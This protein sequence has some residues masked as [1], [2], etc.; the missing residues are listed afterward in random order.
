LKTSAT[1]LP[2]DSSSSESPSSRAIAFFDLD[3]TMTRT[4]VVSFYARYRMN[5]VPKFMRPFWL[6]LF[7]VKVL[8]YVLL[9]K[10][11]RMRFLPVFYRN[12]RGVNVQQ[13]ENWAADGGLRMF[14]D[15]QFPQ[16]TEE[17]H[18]H[19]REGTRVVLLT[20]TI[21]PLARP[22]S[23]QLGVEDV[24]AIELETRDGVYTGRLAGNSISGEEKARI[25]AEISASEGIP[26]SDCYAYG[27][28]ISDFPMLACV[29]H[30][31]AVNPDSRL[32]AEAKRRGWSIQE[33]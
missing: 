12:Y 7:L 25:I 6:S 21:M 19:I 33:W 13:F 16:A 17:A 10:K 18:R 31:T 28:S 14:L 9:E 11:S 5:Y 8:Y 1:G 29:G 22:F 27:D 3:G 26:L 30:P 4:N 15:R 24:I 20:G 2:S 23:K 32:R